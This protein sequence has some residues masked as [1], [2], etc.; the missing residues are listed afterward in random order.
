M[1]NGDVLIFKYEKGNCDLI[2]TFEGDKQNIAVN[3]VIFSKNNKNEY[4]MGCGF[5]NGEIKIYSLKDYNLKFSINSHLRSIGPM[6]IKDNKEIIT[7]SDDGQINIWE[8][9]DNKDKIV[10]KNNILLEDR[11]IVGLAYDNNSNDLFV[12][13][14]D[15][16]EIISISNL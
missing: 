8:Y 6:I 10:L 4:F 15:C 7:G 2:K 1:D 3:S 16:P 5:I 14:Y 9:D 12:S 13:C 11:M